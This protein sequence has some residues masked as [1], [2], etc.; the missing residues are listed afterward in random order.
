[1]VTYYIFSNI[2]DQSFGCTRSCQNVLVILG[3]LLTLCFLLIENPVRM[4]GVVPVGKVLQ[5]DYNDITD[6]CP[7]DGPQEAQ[8]GRAR[9]LLAVRL[10]RKLAEHGL[11]VDPADAF[12][13]FLK[14][15]GCLTEIIEEKSETLS[16]S[17]GLVFLFSL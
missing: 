16:S 6:L 9:D 1:M 14:K 7:K 17:Y 4:Y 3:L 11:L 13:S 15:V 8:P 2:G 12:G 10:V 5:V